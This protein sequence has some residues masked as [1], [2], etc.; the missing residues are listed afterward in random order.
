MSMTDKMDVSTDIN[1]GCS[2]WSHYISV[3]LFKIEATWSTHPGY[4]G[5]IFPHKYLMD[6]KS[7]LMIEIPKTRA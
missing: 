4:S 1:F 5:E 7:R 3:F 6:L 2:P